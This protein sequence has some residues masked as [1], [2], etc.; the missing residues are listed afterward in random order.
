ML[1]KPF[2]PPL[3]AQ[4]PPLIP[5]RTSGDFPV[6]NAKRRRLDARRFLTPSASSDNVGEEDGIKVEQKHHPSKLD[7]AVSVEGGGA[8][9]I[10]TG[11]LYYNVLWYVMTKRSI[12][13]GVD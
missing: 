1:Q 7:H 11:E 5:L 12:C 10:S 3:L 4:R 9:P 8:L 6:P 13:A 2:K